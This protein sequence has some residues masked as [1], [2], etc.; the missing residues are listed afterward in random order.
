MKSITKTK[1]AH[2]DLPG[3]KDK[4]LNIW[5]PVKVAY[6]RYVLWVTHVKVMR[7]HGYGY[8]EEIVVRRADNVL[9]RFKEGDFPRLR[10]NDIEDML[11]LVVQN[12]LTNLSGDDV[13]DFAI[14]LRMF[15]RSLVIQ[16]RVEDLQLG[17]K[18]YQKKIN[19]VSQ[20]STER[21]EYIRD[22]V[23]LG[24]EAKT[25]SQ[26]RL[27]GRP[28]AATK[29]HMILS[30]DVLIIQVDP[31]GFEDAI[32]MRPEVHLVILDRLTK[33]AHF[34]P[35][36]END[37]MDK[38]SRLYLKEV[39]TRHEIPVSV[40]CDRDGRFTSNFWRA[41]QKA[42]GTRLDM[43]T[44]YHPQTDE[45]SKR[46]IQT[47]EDMLRACVID[48]GNGWDRHLPL[49]EF[50]YNNSYH[51]SIKAAP[52]EALYGR[53]CRSLVCWA[54]VGDAQLTGPELIHETTKKIVS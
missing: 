35:M 20:Y 41:F 14:A 29:N 40:I 4:V 34:L 43:S 27:R 15:T 46:T 17:V 49:I 5:S 7:K 39:V 38:F 50:S 23:D 36:R 8:L 18:S 10:I 45:Q 11:I 24:G 21:N 26:E 25:T 53:K 42:L 1:A 19:D 3:I 51:T 54:E 31:H 28:T 44:A 6:D 16:K 37:S 32:K 30:C 2:Y 48:F 9:Y 12:R 33:S 47:L 22:F 52:F 13:A